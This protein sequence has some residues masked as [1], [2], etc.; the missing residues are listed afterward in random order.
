MPA[1]WIARSRVIDPDRYWKYAQQVPEI[2]GRY[3]AKVL[4]RGGESKTVEGRGDFTRFVVLE[5]PSLEQA[6]ACWESAEYQAARE[7]RLHGAGEAEI[8]LLEG[9][10]FTSPQS[11][12]QA[13]S[14][15]RALKLE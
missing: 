6:I 5:F 10:E 3:G 4:A 14:A 15:G 8:T 13:N 2:T 1:Y 9:G 11:L 7:H 12:G